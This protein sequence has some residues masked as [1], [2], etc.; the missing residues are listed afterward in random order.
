MVRSFIEG[1]LGEFGRQLL[2]FYEA[3]ALPINLVVLAYGFMMLMSWT[4][5]LR[6]YRHAVVIVA[7]RVH[8]H[9]NL[10]RKS[11]VK[12]I[13][14]QIEIPWQ[15][16]IDAAPFPLVAR[17]GALIPKQKSVESLRLLLDEKELVTH[18]L[19]VL[20]GTHIRKIMPS[21]RMGLKKETLS[22]DAEG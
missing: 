16:V 8:E 12:Q 21:Y 20:K 22:D 10:T 13:R 1:M 5:L 19:E 18:A 2:Y 17:A 15:E 4:T 14:D 7:R 9:P 11:T 3:H 6:I